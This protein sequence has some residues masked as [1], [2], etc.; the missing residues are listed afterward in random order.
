MLGAVNASCRDEGHRS[1][2]EVDRRAAATREVDTSLALEGLYPTAVGQPIH[3]QWVRGE[4]SGD[5]AVARILQAH[6]GGRG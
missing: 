6:Q 1:A 4:L 5:E 2:S 3:E